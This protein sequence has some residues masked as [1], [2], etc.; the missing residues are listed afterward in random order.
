MIVEKIFE[1]ARATPRAAAMAHNGQVVTYTD[2]AIAILL[3]RKHL[4][5]M[6]LGPG[7]IAVLC[8]NNLRDCW[9]LLLALRSL[10]LHTL[11]VKDAEQAAGLQLEGIGCIVTTEADKRETVGALAAARGWRDLLVPNTVFTP[12]PKPLPMRTPREPLGGHIMLTS[13]TTGTYKMVMISPEM[14]ERRCENIIQTYGFTN[15]SAQYLPDFGTWTAAG[16][17]RPLVSWRTGGTAVF[18][19]RA[20][21][22]LGFLGMPITDAT[23]NVATLSRIVDALPPNARRRDDMRIHVVGG[24]VPWPLA[25]ATIS[26][27]SKQLFNNLGST[28]AGTIASTLIE[29]PGDQQWYSILPNRQVDVVDEDDHAVPPGTVGILRIKLLHGD[30]TSYYGGDARS[31]EF[32]RNG[33]FYP[34]DLAVIGPDGRIA[35]QGRATDVISVRGGDKIATAPHEQ[36]IQ[37]LLGV[38]GV[39]IF[40]VPNAATG[41]DD[42]GVALECETDFTPEHLT[43][44]L[45][46][47]PFA[48]ARVHQLRQ[49]PRNHMGK[50]DRIA[51]RAMLAGER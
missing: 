32:L 5:T 23:L 12:P 24:A 2:L 9:A 17:N 28:E 19:Q 36:K 27:I 44:A 30:I 40:S 7:S 4:Q 37:E 34:G 42:V 25:Q 11:S 20:G 50:I 35:L 8:I 6:K 47:T 3:A 43:K 10:G 41:I 1:H 46:Q 38:R 29:K 16:Y 39:C 15:R 31:S 18:E 49:L 51:L 48:R 26:R 14:E 33:F 22:L 45:G 13:G 21:A